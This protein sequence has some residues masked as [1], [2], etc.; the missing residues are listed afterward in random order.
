MK[1]LLITC[2]VIMCGCA[3]APKRGVYPLRDLTVICNS[4]RAVN[5]AYQ[6]Y[7]LG[8][9]PHERVAGFFVRDTIYVRWDGTT[10]DFH[11]LGHEIWHAIKGEFHP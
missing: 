10:P 1:Y 3:T 11:T 8:Q 2:C 7:T 6:Y 4:D 5:N 9:R